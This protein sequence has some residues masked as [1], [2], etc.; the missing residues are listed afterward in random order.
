MVIWVHQILNENEEKEKWLYSLVAFLLL[1]S[2]MCL[3]VDKNRYFAWKSN[4]SLC[5]GW[6]ISYTIYIKCRRMKWQMAG[7]TE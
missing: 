7:F 2:M 3:S 6:N 1:F 4:R 5:V